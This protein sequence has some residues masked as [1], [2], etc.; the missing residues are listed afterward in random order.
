MN[1]HQECPSDA[2]W[3]RADCAR[4]CRGGQTPEAAARAAGVCPRTVRKWV[5]RFKAEGVAGL[6][7]SLVAAASPASADAAAIV[8]QVEALRRQRWTGKQIAAAGVSPATVSRILK[9]LGLNRIKA[10]E[11]AEPVRRYEREHPGELIHIDIKKL[12]RFERVGHRI[13]G[14]RRQATH[15]PAGP[16]GSSSTSASTTP[17]ASPSPD[18]ARREEKSAVAF[19]KAAVAYYASLGVTVARV[20]TDNGSCYKAFAFVAPPGRSSTSAPGPTRPRPTARPSASSRP[21]CG[22]GPTPSLPHLR[23]PRRAA[24]ALAAQIQLASPAR[25]PKIQ[26]TYQPP[27]PHR[28]QPVEAPQLALCLSMIFS[29]NR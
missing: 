9:R 15:G 16:A 4:S 13:T 27:R 11:P 2:A 5:A 21:R 24:P 20:M 10:L 8:E 7:G 6:A 22:N 14:D 26:N 3:S 29:E 12:G 23:R 25:Q 18:P 19:L 1:I 17:R 28:G